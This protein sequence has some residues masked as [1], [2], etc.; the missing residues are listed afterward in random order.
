MKATSQLVLFALGLLQG[1]QTAQV[2]AAAKD[3]DAA[4]FANNL[5]NMV[6]G[7]AAEALKEVKVPKFGERYQDLMDRKENGGLLHDDAFK[8]MC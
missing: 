3:A 1:A 8:T 6:D 5:I 2:N 4:A 7:P